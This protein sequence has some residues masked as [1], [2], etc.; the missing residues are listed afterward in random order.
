MGAHRV[1]IIGGGF[2][3]LRAARY[4]KK[5]PVNVALVDQ[6]NFHLFQP[7]LYQVATGTLSP[8]NIA[9]P[10]RGILR[11]QKNVEVLMAQAV[12]LDAAGRRVKLA[13]GE[14][15]YDTLIVAAGASY[16]YFHHDAWR[17]L[18]PGL[19]TIDDAT[20]IRRRVL[21]AFEAAERERDPVRVRELLTFVIVGGG[22]TGVELAGALAE[23]ARHTLKEDFRR[24]NPADATIILVEGGSR[25]LSSF[26]E[27]L[28]ADAVRCLGRI[29]VTVELNAFVKD[30][31]P[32]KLELT[33]G[34]ETK[35]IETRVV[36]WA[37]G[38]QAAPFAQALASATGAP[39]DRLGRLMIEPD[40]T[41]PGH[42]EIFVIGDMANF[43]HQGGKPLPGVAPVA[44]QQGA[45][46]A[47]LILKRLAGKSLPPFHYQDKGSLATIGRS[48]AVADLGWIRLSGFPAWLLWLFLHLM[49]L[50][51]FESRVLV[52]IQWVWNY[53][54]FGRSARLITGPLPRVEAALLT[55]EDPDPDPAE[56]AAPARSSS[57]NR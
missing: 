56:D 7:L 35:I 24:I 15:D 28:S 17:P 50:V 9:A 4:F 46:A 14:L 21:T 54:T 26:P 20:D 16:S 6:N 5:A 25:L 23:I 32:G 22:P 39:T 51:K 12:G 27:K 1:V 3:G 43:S 31:Q 29:G 30:V 13:D 11:H 52:F 2:G 36:L 45:Y 49:L 55:P 38:V 42:P 8:A 37:A 44:I 53:F 47:Q 48:A 33:C 34:A 18:A 57:A 19:K 40:L 41:L 10:L